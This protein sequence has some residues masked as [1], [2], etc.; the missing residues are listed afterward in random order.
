MAS[1]D[2]GLGLVSGDVPRRANGEWKARVTTGFCEARTT[3][4]TCFERDMV[5][6]K[7]WGYYDLPFILLYVCV[8]FKGGKFGASPH[9]V[10][11]FQVT[12]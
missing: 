6:L 10:F 12:F 1:W 2:G 11:P 9:S 5:G 3:E 8:L 4:A 7:S